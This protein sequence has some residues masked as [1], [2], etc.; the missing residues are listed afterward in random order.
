MC[1]VLWPDIYVDHYVLFCHDPQSIVTPC[2]RCVKIHEVD[3]S[4]HRFYTTLRNKGS[5]VMH[6]SCN[7]LI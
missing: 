4:K 1:T 6:K 2:H 7:A 5:I 3:V